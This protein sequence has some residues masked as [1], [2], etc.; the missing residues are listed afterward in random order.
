MRKPAFSV[1][2]V[3]VL[4]FVLVACG[5]NGEPRTSP[6]TRPAEQTEQTE[7]TDTS[8]AGDS[9]SEY[10][11]LARTYVERARRSPDPGAGPDAL[12]Q[13]YEEAS[14]EMRAAAEAAPAEIKNDARVVAD[15]LAA[16]VAAF[17]R[18][19]WDP[20]RV[21]PDALNAISTPEF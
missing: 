7:Q 11:Q 10:C 1:F 21:P 3:G 19:G 2:A 6:T 18:V 14:R 12:R 5:G 8:F 17:E 9:E 15:G 16:I 13:L 20:S 4:A